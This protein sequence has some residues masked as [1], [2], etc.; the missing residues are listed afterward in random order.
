[1]LNDFK[2]ALGRVQS[3]YGFYIECQANPAVALADYDLTAEERSALTD[4]A[5]LGD[6]LRRG[7]VARALPRITVTIKGRHDW[8]NVAAGGPRNTADKMIARAVDA[9][10]RAGT[11]E[12]RTQAAVGL[13]GLIG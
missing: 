5:T 9:I 7:D 12:E 2:R 13:M 8:V 6:L 3:D 11:H 4:P 1:V 10:R